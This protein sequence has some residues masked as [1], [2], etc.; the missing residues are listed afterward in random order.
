MKHS[1]LLLLA[2]FFPLFTWAQSPTLVQHVSC[3]N[4]GAIGSGINGAMSSTPDYKCPL[5]ELTQAGNALV[6]GLFSNN[7]NS[8]TYTVSDDKSNTWTLGPSATDSS[9]NTIRIYYALN[10]AAN[11]HMVNIH[12]SALTNGFLA[13]SISEFYNVATSAA[14]DGSSCNASA[15]SGTSITAGS[16][17]PTSGDLIWQFAADANSVRVSPF[18]IG[19]QSNITWA[20][21][22]TDIHDGDASQYGIWSGSG[23]I[24]PTF[25]AGTSEPWD[26]CA[27]ALKQASAGNAPT[28]S[29]RIVHMLHAQQASSE[30][31]PY[32][33]QFPSSGNLLTLVFSSGSNTITGVSSTPSNTWTATGPPVFNGSEADIYY[34]ANASTSNALTFSVAQS[35]TNSGTVFMMYDVA[36]AA[37]SSP[38]DVDSGGQTGSQ[39]STVNSLTTCSNC[40]TPHSAN[41]LVL[42]TF[43]Q[44][45][46][47]ATGI[48]APNGALFDSATY[49]GNS[50]DGPQSVD[51]NNGWFHFYST[52]T[53]ALSA[54]W[55]ETCSSPQGSWAG[56]LVAF[57]P[58][59][60]QQPPSPPTQL[61][62]VVN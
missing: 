42:G 28:K 47:T 17:T 18:I 51:Q 44:A 36:G 27:I 9:G 50:V 55:T 39:T 54:T 52:G 34:A 24:N 35:G 19:S 15:S 2:L 25:T 8:A 32:N 12:L 45:F 6:L 33:G 1:R 30:S 20:F 3:P 49:T 13:V 60:S 48:S 14:I 23:A 5:P 22:G 61:K 56:R 46:C 43:G 40:L 21:L 31:F 57:K 59:S 7:A 29:F 10:I 62:A 58:A 26:S 11:T 53:G 37:T 4:S 38:L 41:E 16:F